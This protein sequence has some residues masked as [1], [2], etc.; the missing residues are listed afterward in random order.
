MLGLN[1]GVLKL[2]TEFMVEGDDEAKAFG[3][4]WAGLVEAFMAGWAAATL[5]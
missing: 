3:E 1:A 2:S 4:E 5:E